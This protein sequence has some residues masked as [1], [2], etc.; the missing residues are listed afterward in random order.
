MS[1][2]SK[3]KLEPREDGGSFRWNKGGWLGAQLGGT[4]WLLIMGVLIGV[5]DPLAG[6]VILVCFAAANLYGWSLW[7]R[8]DELKTK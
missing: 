7:K 3:K 1:M 6:A 8:R 5:E 2:D 4:C